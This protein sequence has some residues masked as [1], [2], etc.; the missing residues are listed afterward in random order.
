[1]GGHLGRWF[2]WVVSV[3]VLLYEF[4]G[5]VE[6]LDRFPGVVC[7]LIAF[8]VDQEFVPVVLAAVVEYL[9]CF[10]FLCIVD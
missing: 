2:C 3:P 7:S 5:V 9:L 6:V 8:P 10:L 1:M 4:K